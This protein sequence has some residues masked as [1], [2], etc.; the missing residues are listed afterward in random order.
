[1]I[2]LYIENKLIELED[3]LEVDFTYETID[4]DKLSS[5]K[6]SFSKTVSIPGTPK[7]NITFG[8]IFRNDKW[9][10]SFIPG[11]PIDSYYDPHKK[12]TWIINKN[13]TLVQRGYCVLNFIDV[14]DDR[15][16][17]YNLTL[18]G[19]LGEF[20]YSL[21]YNDDGTAKT[22]K[23]VY[24]NW[25]PKTT[26]IGYGPAM[27]EGEEQVNTLMYCSSQLIAYAYHLLNPLYTYE[28]TTDIDKDIVFVPCYTGLY[29]NFDSKHILVSTFNQSYAGAP[30]STTTRQELNEVFPQSMT[31]GDTTYTTMSRTFDQYG[32]TYGLASFSRDLD[33]TEAGDLRVNELPVAIR[34]S[35]LLW[36]IT[37]PENCGGYE[38]EWSD[39]I[40]NSYN[41]IYGWLLLGKL[42][43]KTESLSAETVA[44]YTI[45]DVEINYRGVSGADTTSTLP[46]TVT[47][48]NQQPQLSGNYIFRTTVKPK[49]NINL[50]E[51][52]LVA[53]PEFCSGSYFM[54]VT[55]GGS[56]S[57][58][59][60]VTYYTRYNVYALVTS[61]FNGSTRVNT[62]ADLFYYSSLNRYPYS[63]FGGGQPSQQETLNR[64]TAYLEEFY[65][66]SS[67][68][69]TK[70]TLHTCVQTLIN[71]NHLSSS[72]YSCEFEC[73]NEDINVA[74][75][76]ISSLQNLR[77][78]QDAVVVAAG[79]VGRSNTGGSYFIGAWGDENVQ[80]AHT[81]F[82][83]IPHYRYPERSTNWTMCHNEPDDYKFGFD[84]INTGLFL[85]E[86][87]GFNIL[88]LDKTTLFASSD[89]PFKYLADYCKMMNYKFLCD[90]TSKKVKIMQANEYYKD[91]EIDLDGKIDYHRAMSV[92]PVIAKNKII[93]I[94]LAPLDTYPIE[95][96]NRKLDYK[97]G[98]KKFDTGLE[99]SA[100][101]TSLLDN[102]IYKSSSDWQLNSVFYNLY[103]QFPKA[104]NLSTVSWTLF[105]YQD[106]KL[107]KKEFIT[108]TKNNENSS[109]Q[110]L[111]NTPK[112]A[113]FDKSQKYTTGSTFIFL[114]GFVKNYDY[115][116]VS[117]TDRSTYA[118][119]PR[120]MFSND[121]IEQYFFNDGQRCYVWDFKY[122]DV[123]TFWGEYSSDQKGVAT[124]WTL[125]FFTRDLYNE[126]VYDSESQQYKWQSS[127]YKLASWNMTNQN[128]LD[129][130]YSLNNA[131]FIINQSNIYSETATSDIWTQNE[132]SI[133]GAVPQ[134]SAYQT[135]RPYET[136][137]DTQLNDIYDIN[138]RE[139]T[140]YV[141]LTQF[142]D[143]NTILRQ[144]YLWEGSKWIITKIHNF[145]LSNFMK[146]KFTKVTM[147]KVVDIS[148]W[149]NE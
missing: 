104:Y 7:N 147:K 34:L 114:N 6:N 125:P 103:P 47:I 149:V 68:T 29:D 110:V 108:A 44:S 61:I 8:H 15:K 78:T 69:I 120:L 54:E 143:V 72:D 71:Y 25:R 84:V 130:I 49:L 89:S 56:Q 141:D 59:A 32:Y 38:V 48:F 102:L 77:I 70:T 123:F 139:V 94:G 97:F 43:N 36:A 119:A 65:N 35:K 62:Q 144:T 64:V 13:G 134:D 92:N 86:T 122:N 74:V 23:D 2:E 129:G 67:G 148:A 146:D 124:S 98:I 63:V 33:P 39:S 30:L 95:L 79:W 116:L 31:D 12:V 76:G 83:G 55:G 101:N 121:T 93:D 105:N 26:L 100:T 1:M 52:N 80:I 107:N 10:E 16:V 46:Q 42:D 128:G 117:S 9:L 58:P 145:K 113:V 106:S 60:F 115:T 138:S 53:S 45:G 136:M 24:F 4:P 57:H 87:I 118:I 96:I 112:L 17:T 37:R 142:S 99:Y 14:E 28:G 90:H 51:I 41:F 66:L 21:A 133:D 22:L 20:F 40:L 11:A 127:L 18:Y 3:E 131:T 111:D 19:G 50:N 85:N 81:T 126:Y 75:P 91:T 109:L 137:W 27:N 88:N 73:P 135:I 82:F 140:L 5:I 132:Y